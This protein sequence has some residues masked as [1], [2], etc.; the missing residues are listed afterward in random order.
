M[1][2]IAPTTWPLAIHTFTQGV[3]MLP[4]QLRLLHAARNVLSLPDKPQVSWDDIRDAIVNGGNS[5]PPPE[6]TG[7]LSGFFSP[8]QDLC[9][10]S[11]RFFHKMVPVK[12]PCRTSA[13]RFSFSYLMEERSRNSY[14]IAE[15]GCKVCI[16]TTQSWRSS[17][18]H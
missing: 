3:G 9:I 17:C 5:S 6:V 1:C 8:C 14:Q 13:R 4:A 18:V 15:L 7:L 2:H 10:F 12:S 11:T 16:F